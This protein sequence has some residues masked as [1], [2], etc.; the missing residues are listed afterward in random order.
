M[1]VSGL[2]PSPLFFM[3]RLMRHTLLLLF[4]LLNL[5]HSACGQGRYS[6]WISYPTV[7]STSQIWFRHTY[8]TQTAPEQA[9]I[10][11]IS[12]GHFELFVNERNVSND[13]MVPY[14]PTLSDQPVAITYDVSRF[15]RPDSN[16]IAVWYAPAYPHL[17]ERQISLSYYGKMEDGQ[18]FCHVS[19]GDWLCHWAN[20]SLLPGNN[21]RQD[22]QGY[23]LR[24]NSNEI[25]PACWLSA[26]EQ[27]GDDREE[28]LRF[29]S[30]Y[31]AEKVS[32]ILQGLPVPAGQDSVYYNFPAT[33]QG[34]IRVT[35]R[36]AKS[37][38]RIYIGGL[39]YIC[40]GKMDE[41]AY[42]KFTMTSNQQVLICGDRHFRKSQIQKVEAL[43]I[44]PYFHNS[45][46]Y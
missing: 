13:V 29:S 17:N 22:G 25:D 40:N 7:D 44:A 35:I 20:R 14:R 1:I 28:I 8:V 39:E 41:Q 24:W 3:Q 11:L 18:P 45:Y 26:K 42:R 9:T 37:G 46:L 23:S 15:L 43:E 21:E 12:T 4:I 5:V 19:D 36:N 38:E 33:T 34:W 31:P 2:F 30:F 32:K 27:Q 6:H 16:T 10:T